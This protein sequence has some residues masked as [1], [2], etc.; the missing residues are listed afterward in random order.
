MNFLAHA[1][2]AGDDDALLAGNLMGDF[3]RGRPDPELPAG[4]RAGIHMHRR[5]DCFTDDHPVV[6]RA[7]RRFPP[8]RRR[9]AGIILDMVFDHFLARDWVRLHP[10]P[11]SQFTARAYAALEARHGLLPPRLARLLPQ[12]RADDWLASYACLDN[13]VMALERMSTRLPR[14]PELLRGTGEDLAALYPALERDFRAF[15]PALEAFG[16]HQ[17]RRR[18]HG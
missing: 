11:L 6:R 9:A 4:V 12:M 3:V 14:R 10:E 8:H 2:L 7:R 18:T 15:L 13:T 16:E 1:W 5:V 17:R